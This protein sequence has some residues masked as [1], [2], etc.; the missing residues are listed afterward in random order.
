[1]VVT[2][3]ANDKLVCKNGIKTLRLSSSHITLKMSY[4]KCG[5]CL[6]DLEVIK[7]ASGIRYIRCLNLKECPFFCPE[8]NINGYQHCIYDRVVPEY[9]VYEGGKPLKCKHMDTPT[10][11]VSRSVNNPFRPY[12]TCRRKEMCRYFQWADEIPVDTYYEN[13]PPVYNPEETA[14]LEI[15]QRPKLMRQFART[16]NVTDSM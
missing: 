6:Q 13:E 2:R 4:S 12:F 14:K 5:L 16:D 8:E 7:P 11:R 15:I 3:L 9:K 10:L 1:M